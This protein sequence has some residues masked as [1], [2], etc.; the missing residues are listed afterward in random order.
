MKSDVPSWFELRP[1]AIHGT[2]AFARRCI[3]RGTHL[4]EYVGEKITKAESRHRCQ[5]QNE[6]IFSLDE[7]WDLDGNVSWNPARFINHSC[8]PN[9]EAEYRD[10]R[11]WI[12]AQRDI[13]A[14]EELTFNYGYDLTDYREYPCRCQAA[15]CVGY[16]VADEFHPQLRGQQ[17]SS[18]GATPGPAW[19]VP[20]PG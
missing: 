6:Y 9:C 13:T 18:G 1:S 11:I 19:L 5:A 17:V 7:D 16:I 10:G 4:T 20:G 12:V 14:G 8:E 2:G 15:N 3:P